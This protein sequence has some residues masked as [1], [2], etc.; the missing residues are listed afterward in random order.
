[1]NFGHWLRTHSQR[2]LLEDAQARLARRYLNRPALPEG[3]GLESLF[4]RRFF[5]PAYR[6]LPWRV[7][8]LVMQAMPGS[9]RQRW[10]WPSRRRPPMV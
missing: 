2:Y 4:W 6:R 8:Q 1:M 5:V 10:H 9:H 3:T 7:R